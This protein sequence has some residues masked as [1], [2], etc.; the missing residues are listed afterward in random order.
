[1]SNRPIQPLTE[2]EVNALAICN[3]P[4]P[5]QVVQTIKA[6]EKA[7]ADLGSDT[8]LGFDTETRPSF[9]RGEI[10]PVSLLQLAGAQGVVLIRLNKIPLVPALL[11][12]LESPHVVK[13]GV[14]I[15]N[16]MIGLQRLAP[17]TPAGHVDLARLA[18]SR[19]LQCFGLRP[20]AALLMHCRI[21]KRARC[22]NWANETL[23]EAQI[24][25]AAT[26]AWA[27]RELYLRLNAMPCVSS[28]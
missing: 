1:M 15:D 12:L 19:G 24:R 16:D 6:L 25:Y 2:D 22:S 11:Q 20:L 8:V 27:S 5:V 10:Y 21:S 26:D 4:G 13:A 3:F 28:M 9:K 17:F 7:L 14:A 18:K 23:T